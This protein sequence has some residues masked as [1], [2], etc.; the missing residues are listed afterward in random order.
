MTEPNKL[1]LSDPRVPT[2]RLA[3]QDWPVPMLAI[4]QNEMVT[5]VVVKWMPVIAESKGKF[6]WA[7]SE[8]VREL[9]DAAYWALRRAHPALTREEF[10]GWTI[11]LLE[12]VG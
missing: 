9:A 5:P 7:T 8:A 4:E 11:N 12:L 2:I 1:Q 10:N 6:A 3:D